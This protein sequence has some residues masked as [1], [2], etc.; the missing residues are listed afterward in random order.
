M[1]FSVFKDRVCEMKESNR[2]LYLISLF[3]VRNVMVFEVAYTL[4]GD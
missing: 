4:S 2:L 1:L 3:Y